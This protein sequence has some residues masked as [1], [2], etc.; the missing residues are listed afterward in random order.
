MGLDVLDELIREGDLDAAY[1][2][3]IP[4]FE[5]GFTKVEWFEE[6]G[7]DC[8]PVGHEDFYET[9]VLQALMTRPS[10]SR[11]LDRDPRD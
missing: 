8:V 10:G 6:D 1:R 9:G 2:D 5:L 4:T 11:P 3:L 7:L